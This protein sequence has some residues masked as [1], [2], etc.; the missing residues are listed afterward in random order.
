M[1]IQRE[2]GTD[3]QFDFRLAAAV[4][5]TVAVFSI[6]LGLSYPLLTLILE[7]RGISPLM[8]GL[9]AAM[10]PLGII[11]SAPIIPQLAR[12]IGAGRLA[13]GFGVTNAAIFLSLALIDSLPYW[14]F[15]R[16]IL[17]ASANGLFVLSETWV[18][19]LA[20][21]RVRGRV[22]A[23]FATTTALGFGAGPL[24]LVITGS[25]TILPFLIGGLTMVSAV[26]V[27]FLVRRRL[28]EA[29]SDQ[30]ATILMFARLAPILLFAAG[31]FALFDQ[32][33]LVMLPLF[34]IENGKSEQFTAMALTV[35]ILGN[36][37]LQVPI[38][39]AADRL[40]REP[41][42]ITCTLLTALIG[43]LFPL[44]LAVDALFWL[45][46]FVWGSTA[47]GIYTLSLAELGSRF[48]GT[49]LIAGN[50]AFGLMWGVGGIGG[51]PII[52]GSMELFGPSAL[53]IFMGIVFT[54]L[55][56]LVARASTKRTASA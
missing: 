55:L 4:I 25:E 50:A 11:L 15:G 10:S 39:W 17:G 35:L 9:N 13:I 27:I 5:A 34:L 38:G 53:P 44:T 43:F 7:S 28:P 20:T 33:V 36:V 12:K 29:Q 49:M 3:F 22:M 51:T 52:G 8:I 47:F 24:V 45:A 30:P 40:G 42:L 1:A 6:T 18:N 37:F 41:L 48:R 31:A 16:L 56:A 46:V 19:L 32:G 14:F 54:C 2:Q 21:E 26:I 23:V